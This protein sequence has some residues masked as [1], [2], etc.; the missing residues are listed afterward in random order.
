M[1]KQ[2]SGRHI[3]TPWKKPRSNWSPP[4]LSQGHRN[5]ASFLTSALWHAFN[6]YFLVLATIFE[7][8]FLI[9]SWFS[10]LAFSMPYF[11]DFPPPLEIPVPV[12]LTGSSFEWKDLRKLDSWVSSI[13][14]DLTV[15][16]L[17]KSICKL[18]T[19][20]SNQDLSSEP[21]TLS[22]HTLLLLMDDERHFK[23]VAADTNDFS[24][25]L[26]PWRSLGLS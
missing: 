8:A 18:I 24:L 17:Q 2:R 16:R 11:L 3:I 15:Y 23:R 6:S 26:L 12:C 7:V 20:I 4:C 19:F 5:K 22:S 21:Q 13:H 1:K 10:L 14:V 25:S 9:L